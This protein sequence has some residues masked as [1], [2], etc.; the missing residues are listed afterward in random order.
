MKPLKGYGRRYPA[1]TD[2]IGDKWEGSTPGTDRAKLS[3]PLESPAVH[4]DIFE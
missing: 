3:P 2:A 1:D 4:P